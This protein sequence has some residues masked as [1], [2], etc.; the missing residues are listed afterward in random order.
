MMQDEQQEFRKYK[1]KCG[2]LNFFNTD[3]LPLI[4]ISN[5][6]INIILFNDI[7]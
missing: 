3:I 6:I 5:K 2:E 1:F 4:G 7:I